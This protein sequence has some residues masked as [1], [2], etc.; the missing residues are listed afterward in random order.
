MKLISHFAD[1]LRDT[2]NLNQT[3]IDNLEASVESIKKFIKESDWQPRIWK[4]FEQGSWAHKTIIRPVEGSEF[5]ADLLV[6]VEPVENWT[7]AEYVVSLGDVFAASGLYKEKIEVWDYCVTITYA[8]DRK[9]DVAPCV[10][11][12][13]VDGLLEVC[14]QTTGSFERT[15]P[16]AYTDWLNDRDGYSGSNSFRKITRM[17]KYLR[18]IRDNFECPSVLLTTLIGERIDWSD[19]GSDAFKDVP[20]T[21][22][23]TIGRLD[24]WMQERAAKPV[25]ANPKLTSEDFALALSQEDYENLRDTI[26]E[27]RG[28]IDTA[29]NQAGRYDSIKAWREVF[30]DKFAKGVTILSKALMDVERE[31]N[32]DEDLLLAGV[33][34]DDAAH[35]S[36]IVDLVGRVGRWLWKPSFDRPNH[37]TKPMWPRA[38]FV[39]DQVQ[40]HATWQTTRNASFGREVAD[41]ETLSPTGGLWFDITVNEGMALPDG[42]YVRYRITNTGA[43]AIALRQGRGDFEVPQEGTQRWEKL[44]YRGVHLAEAFIVRRADGRL[45]GQSA[46]FH[47]MI[48]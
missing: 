24:D 14:N 23:T 17:I 19:K 33:V 6:I 7:A 28:K 42:F 25:V 29:Y 38:D 21:L 3:R 30:G 1:F 41:F 40:V 34:K 37:M 44:E 18:D 47:V 8:G 35:D 27:I 2:V 9:I 26:H 11:G 36:R 15:E 20:T 10:R 5:D 48:A 46:P 16:V 45:V 12:R 39:S 22:K 32:E 43:V 4:Y 31:F 13:L